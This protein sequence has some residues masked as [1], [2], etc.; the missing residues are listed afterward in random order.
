MTATESFLK[1]KHILA[2]DDEE[3]RLL[4]EVLVSHQIDQGVVRA[5][6]AH[7][8]VP[9][10]AVVEVVHRDVRMDASALW[11]VG[12]GDEFPPHHL[13]GDDRAALFLLDREM[14]KRE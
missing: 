10:P 5:H 9:L 7:V 12:R 3:E 6:V 11:R 8:E 1:G 2:V 14:A 4:P 13:V